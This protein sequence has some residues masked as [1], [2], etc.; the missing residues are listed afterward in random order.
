MVC[1]A[2]GE[3]RK[4]GVVGVELYQVAARLLEVVPDD[5]VPFDQVV[6]REPVG[7]LLVELG[8]RRLRQ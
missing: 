1:S 8:S 2:H 5:L 3:S 7:E 4:R 6:R